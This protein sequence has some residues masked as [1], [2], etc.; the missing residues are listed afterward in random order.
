MAAQN[1]VELLIRAKNLSTKTIQQLNDELGKIADNQEQVADANKL[2]E[3][4]LRD[5]MIASNRY[6]SCARNS[7]PRATTSTRSRSSSTIP[8]SRRRNSPTS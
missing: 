2:A 3:R 6:A 5:F 1:E 7:T 4:S 8:R